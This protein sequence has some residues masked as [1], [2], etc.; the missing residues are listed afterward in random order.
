LYFDVT[1]VYKGAVAS[2]PTI[3]TLGN[4]GCA[5]EPTEGGRHLIFG[6]LQSFPDGDALFRSSASSASPPWPHWCS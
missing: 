6:V 2:D 4:N 1:E 3:A 5:D